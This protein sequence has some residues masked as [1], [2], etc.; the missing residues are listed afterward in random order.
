MSSKCIQMNYKFFINANKN[1]HD[2]ILN[3][4][5]RLGRYIKGSDLKFPF[6]LSISST[7]PQGEFL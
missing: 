6:H 2:A 4:I 3:M 1:A 5:L 7:A